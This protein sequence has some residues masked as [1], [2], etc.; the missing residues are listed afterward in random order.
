MD[1]IKHT[2]SIVGLGAH[3]H[4][5]THGSVTTG[6]SSV[7]NK[8]TSLIGA[9]FHIA[10]IVDHTNGV[11]EF[12]NG[13]QKHYHDHDH[14]I[15]EDIF[16]VMHLGHTLFEMAMEPSLPHG[17][18]T[19]LTFASFGYHHVPHHYYEYSMSDVLRPVISSGLQSSLEA[20]SL[21]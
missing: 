21:N 8:L 5:H 18:Q 19:V 14:G 17:I 20:S 11:G 16:G 3:S 4:S 6:S 15:W 9:G 2:G 7:F 12:I 10:E 1:F 13:G